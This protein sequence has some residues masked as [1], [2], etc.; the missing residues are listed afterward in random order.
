MARRRSTDANSLFSSFTDCNMSSCVFVSDVC[1]EV[2]VSVCVCRGVRV[3]VCMSGCE[4][5]VCRGV[6]V[7]VRVV[8]CVS[9]GAQEWGGWIWEKVLRVCNCA[10]THTHVYVHVHAYTLMAPTSQQLEHTPSRHSYEWV[11]SYIWMSHVTCMHTWCTGWL[12]QVG[13]LKLQVSFAK[14]PYKRDDILQKRSIFLRSL[15]IVATP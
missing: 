7:R 3:A 15:L 9:L 12:R 5:G 6:C 10:C 1:V 8:V 2:C 13:S 14:E 11:M 4:L